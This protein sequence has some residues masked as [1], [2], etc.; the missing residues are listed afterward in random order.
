MLLLRAFRA[1]DDR[2]TCLKFLEGHGKVLT[3][4]GVNKVT[5][6]KSDW[7]DNPASYVI[8]VEDMETK[9]VL[10]GA[11]VQGSGGTQ[12]LPIAEATGYMDNSIYSLIDKEAEH[13]TGEI[14]GLWNSR[15]VAGL[16]FGSVFLTRAAVVISSKI[17]MKSLF[18]LCAPYTV[19]TAE[20]FGYRTIY[21]L[22][23]DG[24]FY[25]PT[26]DLLATAMLLEDTSKLE[27][28][29]EAE[30]NRIMNLREEPVQTAIETNKNREVEI[31]YQLDISVEIK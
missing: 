28:A 20:Y 29:D 11:R 9:D 24:T 3:S 4:I 14:C 8:A 1:I 17:G 31:A 5:S 7:V 23:K 15:K 21:S 13:G 19:K 22:G 2:E 27:Y 18:A 10:G 26:L 12:P 6:S 16:G 30:R 25:Y